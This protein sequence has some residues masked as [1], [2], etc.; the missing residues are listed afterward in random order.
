MAEAF[1]VA[2]RQSMVATADVYDPTIP[3]AQN[4]ALVA[5]VRERAGAWQDDLN[6]EMT[7]IRAKDISDSA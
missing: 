5:L 2:D 6:A 7:A 4:E 1:V 3:M